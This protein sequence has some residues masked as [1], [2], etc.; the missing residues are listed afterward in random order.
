M[1]TVE[2]RWSIY[3][4]HYSRNSLSMFMFQFF[5]NKILRV[6]TYGNIEKTL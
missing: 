5:H 1:L 4:V 2:S 3:D 6:K